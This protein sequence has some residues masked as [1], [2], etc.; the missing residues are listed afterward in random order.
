MPHKDYEVKKQKERERYAKIMADP[1][2]AKRYKEQTKKWKENNKQKL[3]ETIKEKKA[4]KKAFLIEMLGGKCVGCG[5]TEN[6]QFDHIDRK[7][8]SFTIGKM[9]GYSLENKLIPEAK[10]CQLLCKSCHQIKTTINHDMNSLANG[11]FISN[12]V[13]ND[14]EVVVTLKKL[15][16]DP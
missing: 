7:Q 10:K 2:R 12:V 1:E 11:Y 13:Q 6:L 5:I 3:N 9:L 4:K 15:A 16:Q 8:K 14:D